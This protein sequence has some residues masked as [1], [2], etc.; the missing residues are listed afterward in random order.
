MRD[1]NYKGQ[2]FRITVPQIFMVVGITAAVAGTLL[3][4]WYAIPVLLLVFAGILLAIFLQGLSG[5]IARHTFLSYGWSLTFV[6]LD[7]ATIFLVSLSLIAPEVADQAYHLS[8]QLPEALQRLK[9][10][11]AQYTW[12][13][14]L[15]ALIGKDLMPSREFMLTQ[16]SNI[17]SSTLDVLFSFIIILFIGLYGAA[18]PRLYVDGIIRLIPIRKRQRARMVLHQVGQTLLWWLFG[19]MISMTVVGMLTVPGLWLLGIPNILTLGLL[20]GLLTFIPYVGPVL[21]VVPAA[22]L[23]LLQS[24]IQVINVLLLYLF[25][26]SFEGYLLTPLV[27]KRTVAMPPILTISVQVLFGTLLGFFGLMLATP[28][29]AALMVLIRMLYVEDILG[30]SGKNKL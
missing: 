16:A 29:V 18:Q 7:L 6:V 15:L 26:Q 10:Y 11:F 27:Q 8:Q 17:F 9:Q 20:A 4:L 24:P 30:N 13:Q 2:Y 5:W 21:S 3:F 14:E 22:L 19:R 12:G 28:L 1:K 23:A 25:L